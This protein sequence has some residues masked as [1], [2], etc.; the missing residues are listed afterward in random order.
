MYNNYGYTPYYQ[1]RYAG[2]PQQPMQQPMAQQQQV[3]PVNQNNLIG[4]QVDSIDMVKAIEYPLDGSIS[5]YPLTS[6]E[7]I[8]TKQLQL[9]GTSKMIIYRPVEEDKKSIPKYITKEDLESVLDDYGVNGLDDIKD[10]LKAL[11][12]EIKDIKGKKNKNE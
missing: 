8:V 4:K 10:D 6:G 1:Q 3:I 5:Y 12:K 7:A 2:L 11:K 9:D